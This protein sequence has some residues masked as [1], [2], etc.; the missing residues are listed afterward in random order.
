MKTSNLSR[1]PTLA[2]SFHE[3]A[4]TLIQ[5]AVTNCLATS[6]KVPNTSQKCFSTS[7]APSLS[8]RC[9]FA[10]GLVVGLVLP[11]LTY[12]ITEDSKTS[13]LSRTPRHRNRHGDRHGDR[14]R[15]RHG[16]RQID[17]HRDRQTDIG[18]DKQT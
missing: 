8:N 4:K 1:T 2:K 5:K 7:L 11:E 15:N 14:H 9:Q 6:L 3:I 10:L 12:I 16:D 17:R 18:T 13:I